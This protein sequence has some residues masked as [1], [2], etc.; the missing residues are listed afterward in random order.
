[1][2]DNKKNQVKT[3][4]VKTVQPS[5]T[6]WTRPNRSA[7]SLG[8]LTLFFFGLLCGAFALG[9]HAGDDDRFDRMSDRG[10]RG[11]MYDVRRGGT[12]EPMMG[13]G[14]GR[15]GGMM[16]DDGSAMSTRVMGVV[17]AVDDDTIMVSGNGTT[18]KVS[19][20]DN[21]AYVGEDKPAKVHDTIMANGA[22]QA[23]GSLLAATV[24]LSRQ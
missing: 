13:D 5:K 15:R 23:D 10:M 1:M 8:L 21:T 2:V 19:V 11:G 9:K 17:T 7:L 4:D 18:T 14:F 16:A 12:D 6:S 24:R 22:R 20:N 3:T